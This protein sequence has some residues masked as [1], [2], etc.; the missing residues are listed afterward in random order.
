MDD[1]RNNEK[2]PPVIKVRLGKFINHRST[3]ITIIILI[4]SSVFIIILDAAHLFSDKTRAILNLIGDGITIVF[5]IE[6]SIRFFA[7]EN[8]PRF[9]L[10]YAIDIIAVI[11]VFRTF[12]ILRV[13]RLLRIFRLG[14]LLG[15]RISFFASIFRKGAGEHF[16]ILMIITIVVLTGTI[17]ITHVENNN[18]ELNSFKKALWWSVMSLVAAEPIGN[19]PATNTGKAIA[20]L[21][22]LGG[23]TVFAMFTGVVSAVMVQRLKHTMEGHEMELK[24]IEHH[25]IICG[26][27]RSGRGIIEEFQ[28][29]NQY[30]KRD[31][32]IM[33]EL[34]SE[35]D[36]HLNY[37]VINREK[38]YFISADYT[39]VKYLK[40]AGVDR[41]D[42][43]ILLADKSLPRS[44]QDR[45]ARTILAA[46][47]IEK[48]NP[49]IF[50]CVELLN[51]D[52]DSHLKMIGVEEIVVGDEYSGNIVAASARNLGFIPIF[53][54]LLT[55]KY[56]NQFYKLPIPSKWIGKT[57]GEMFSLLKEKYEATLIALERT[58]SKQNFVNPPADTIL[59]GGDK[60]VL[61][62]REYPKFN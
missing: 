17:G 20:L 62:A 16:L 23:M 39:N 6:L 10:E 19:P 11:P 58:G 55:S 41:A 3:D 57:V 33:A 30:K 49:K 1:V 25:T 8:R 26:W 24:E 32:V 45:D 37:N 28:S 2:L 42:I 44:D 4:L 14:L 51:R 22:M 53:D 50:T 12:R 5:I 15:R 54:E 38:V 60:I 21:V 59:E 47:T 34:E 35:N 61:I 13:L 40:K 52:N 27:N 7:A 46:L 43:A 18:P 29:D 9:F 36:L 31:I 48:L 56:G